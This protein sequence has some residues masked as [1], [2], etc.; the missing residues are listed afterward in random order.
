MTDDLVKRL[1]DAHS[2]NAPKIRNEAADRIEQL[3][4][5]LYRHNGF[6]MMEPHRE[7][8]IKSDLWKDTRAALS[9]GKVK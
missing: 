5:L 6:W 7:W 9:E 8:Y 4:K 1:R 2:D 3:E